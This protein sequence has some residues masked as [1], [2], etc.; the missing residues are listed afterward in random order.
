ML[1]AG[2]FR[3][4]YRGWYHYF[5]AKYRPTSLWFHLTPSCFLSSQHGQVRK[6]LFNAHP[7]PLSRADFGGKC[8]HFAFPTQPHIEHRRLPFSS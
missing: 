1:F 8:P 5:S 6:V 4:S 2:L 3:I 7:L